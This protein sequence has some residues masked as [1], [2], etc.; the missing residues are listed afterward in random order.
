MYM[1]AR[2]LP[3]IAPAV[4]ADTPQPGCDRCAVRRSNAF[5]N[6]P[7]GAFENL[8]AISRKQQLAAGTTLFAT[9]EL[10]HGAFIVCEGVLQVR[11]A[12]NGHPFPWRA[13]RG[14]IVGLREALG[15]SAYRS[16]A[17][18][19]TDCQLRFIPEPALKRLLQTNIDS[20]LQAVHFA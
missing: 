10:C 11:N 8:Q 6:L 9:G 5:C 20:C 12:G 18:A 13:S 14:D 16:T 1:S 7:R 2:P 17:V 3:A 4:P 19:V 15:A